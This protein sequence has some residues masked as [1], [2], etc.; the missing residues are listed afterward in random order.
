MTTKKETPKGGARKH[1]E[2]IVI[3]YHKD[4]KVSRKNQAI[5]YK[6]PDHLKIPK[7]IGKLSK[8]LGLPPDTV[9]SMV[10]K[11]EAEGRVV[12]CDLMKCDQSGRWCDHYK[13][14]NAF[15]IRTKNIYDILCERSRT[16]NM[17]SEELGYGYMQVRQ[18]IVYL[19]NRGVVCYSDRGKCEVTGKM[20]YYL[21]VMGRHT[22]HILKWKGGRR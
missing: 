16:I 4:S 8:E 14:G 15:N 18:S 6:I 13:A 10:K 7:S 9:R 5:R 12:Y 11:L 21:R 3:G 1:G 19:I 20:A 22:D 17:L 2:R